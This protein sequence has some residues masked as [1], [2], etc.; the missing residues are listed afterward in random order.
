M[1][2]MDEGV[3]E[4]MKARREL[5]KAHLAACAAMARFQTVKEDATLPSDERI[6]ARSLLDQ[7]VPLC[8]AIL[9]AMQAIPG[10]ARPKVQRV[11]T[12]D[13]R[14]QGCRAHALQRA[15]WTSSRRRS[16]VRWPPA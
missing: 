14:P 16:A 1:S 11:Q 15:Y 2:M 8:K 7:T 9:C 3:M 6:A 5:D 12:S 13:L 10:V 4:L